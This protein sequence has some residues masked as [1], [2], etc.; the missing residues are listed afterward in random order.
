[1]IKVNQDE[2]EG[3]I[4]VTGDHPD[5]THFTCTPDSSNGDSEW[6]RITYYKE[7]S[8]LTHTYTER[9]VLDILREVYIEYGSPSM[10]ETMG[11]AMNREI[12]SSD[13]YV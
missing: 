10:L 7:P 2:I 8:L 4:K 3:L 9:E 11:R 1:M 6:D 12:T 13:L 5:A